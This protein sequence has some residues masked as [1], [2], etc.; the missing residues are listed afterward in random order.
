MDKIELER[1]G[2]SLEKNARFFKTIKTL[3]KRKIGKRGRSIV[4]HEADV[5]KNFL[6]TGV[7]AGAIGV[8]GA[9]I[10]GV[11]SKASPKSLRAIAPGRFKY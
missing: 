7:A 10:A 5:A 2:K 4:R 9:G 1:F 11:S 8:G 6:G 3:T